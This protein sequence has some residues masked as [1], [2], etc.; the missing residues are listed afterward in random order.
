MSPH[1]IAL[2]GSTGESEV[3][4]LRLRK[5][6]SINARRR[7]RTAFVCQS[8]EAEGSCP[9]RQS[10]LAAGSDGTVYALT[11]NSDLISISELTPAQ[12][13]RVLEL[14]E[15]RKRNPTRHKW[16]ASPLSRTASRAVDPAS[17]ELIPLDECR[18]GPYCS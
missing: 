18:I 14:F 1:R 6:C 17:L 8:G 5:S 11:Y 3:G 2:G 7:Q 16:F 15:W 4:K 9:G 13:D 12:R 10:G